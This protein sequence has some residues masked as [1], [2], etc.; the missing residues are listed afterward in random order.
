MDM[1]CIDKIIENGF[2]ENSLISIKPDTIKKMEYL[3]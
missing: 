1:E 2:N 3:N